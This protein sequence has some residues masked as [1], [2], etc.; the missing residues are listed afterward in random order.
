MKKA[1]CKEARLQKVVKS[2]PMLDYLK[3]K[4][5]IELK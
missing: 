2:L 4:I 1:R 5:Q 3:E